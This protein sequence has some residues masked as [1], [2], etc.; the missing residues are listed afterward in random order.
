MNLARWL[1]RIEHLHPAQI[2]L[3][4]GRTREVA[5]RLR[6]LP[7]A[8]PTIMV[9]GT[10]GK[11]S[12]A[13]LIERLARQRGLRTGLYTSPHIQRFNERVRLNGLPVADD[14]LCRAFASVDQARDE[15]PLTYFEF[16]TLAALEIFRHEAPDLLILEVGLGGR[17]DAVNVVD[18]D[19]SVV[20][21]I[22]LDHTDWLGDSRELIALEKAGIRRANRPLLWG[23]RDLP[24][25][26]VALC[27]QERVTLLRAGEDFGEEYGRLSWQ[28]GGQVK[29]VLLEQ[30]VALGVDNLACAVQALAC[31]DMLP[32]KAEIAQLAAS[33]RLS[34][35][36]HQLCI[37]GVDW[38]LDVGHNAEALE[39]FHDLLPAHSGRQLALVAMLADK[40]AER[41][42]ASFLQTV[43]GWY[44][45]GLG[46]PRGRTAEALAQ[47]LPNEAERHL[48]CSV[49]DAVAA[50][51]AAAKPGDR[52]LVFGSF[53]TVAEAA[54][55]LAVEL[56]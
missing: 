1:A 55:A 30:P 17:L 50:L 25:E 4:L 42:L 7:M 54:D 16:T 49:A 53:R 29:D 43:D 45:A 33:T 20:T 46:G 38:Y 31:L 6:L 52:V 24:P 34:G 9:A 19:V 47:A 23:S 35:R 37:D 22:G 40:P 11:G 13:T 28:Q 14:T 3:G 39:R 8:M 21:S 56:E 2:E 10:N 51:R 26:V 12:T 48:S 36:C 41:A 44:L 32:T 15:T 18:A 5:G 27:Q